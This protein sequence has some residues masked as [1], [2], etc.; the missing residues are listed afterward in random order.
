MEELKER[1]R[2]PQKEEKEDK[3]ML[4]WHHRDIQNHKKPD[5]LSLE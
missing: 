1:R 4:I 5:E 3:T 2:T